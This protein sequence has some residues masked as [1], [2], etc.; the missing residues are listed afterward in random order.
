MDSTTRTH[1]LHPWR[2]CGR[3]DHRNAVQDGTSCWT[4]MLPY[5]TERCGRNSIVSAEGSCLHPKNLR[6][7]VQKFQKEFIKAGDA[8]QGRTP[9]TLFIV[10][11]PA[12]SQSC[13]TGTRNSNRDS[14]KWLSRRMVERWN[15]IATN[16]CEKM[17][18]GKTTY[19]RKFGVTLDGLVIPLGSNVS[20]KT[21][22][23]PK[24]SHGCVT[25]GK[26]WWLGRGALS[27]VR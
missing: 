4:Q 15:V 7:Y 20:R 26:R 12:V 25:S 5:A 2:P 17:A 1:Q 10:Q 22:S 6:E 27:H 8:L 14:S 16:V 3:N 23:S 19:D 18:D 21:T 11:K 13:P 9:R 24:L